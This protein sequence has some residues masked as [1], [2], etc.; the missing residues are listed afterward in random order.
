MLLT[1]RDQPNPPP[2][3]TFSA[4]DLIAYGSRRYS[5]VQYLS[6]QFWIRWR[7]EFLHTLTKRHKWRM[8]KRCISIGD[9]VIVRDQRTS[10]NHW[11][12]ARVTAVKRSDDNLVR[13]VTLALPSLPG[14]LK[15]RM[16]RRPVSELVL[17][18]PDESHACPANPASER[19]DG[20]GVSSIPRRT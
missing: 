19:Q 12:M 16:W 8:K 18:V 3:E 15:P 10:R 5:L 11:P 6:D 14:S 9:I 17:L 1:L 4:R 13:Y 2:L 20:W 7:K